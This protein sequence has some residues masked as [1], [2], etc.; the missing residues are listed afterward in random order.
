MPAG[1]VKGTRYPEAQMESLYILGS[2]SFDPKRIGIGGGLLSP[3]PGE[4]WGGACSL[5]RSP[6]PMAKNRHRGGWDRRTA[7]ATVKTWGGGRSS[8]S[9]LPGSACP[10]R[11]RAAPRR[12]ARDIGRRKL[13]VE[14]ADVL[15][16]PLLL[17]GSGDRHQ[18]G[19]LREHPGDRELRDRAALLLRHRLD[20]LR[21]ALVVREIV[22]GIARLALPGV[23][24]GQRRR[25]GDL[26]AEQA[27]PDRR[28]G[29]ERNAELARGACNAS[30]AASR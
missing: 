20:L 23:A 14:R 11:R 28:I 13:H 22:A 10:W 3:L 12:E 27:A 7:F 16:E 26:G 19:A 25:I 8:P 30:S 29:D 5:D 18:V 6:S 17:L 15:R 24:V 9:G 21:E 2:D 4:C 1:A